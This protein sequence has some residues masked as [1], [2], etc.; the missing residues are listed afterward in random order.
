MQI[1]RFF[2]NKYVFYLVVFLSITNL[3]GY[4]SLRQY[5][6]LLFF[7]IV[8]LIVNFFTQNISIILLSA[9]LVTNIFFSPSKAIESMKGSS[10]EETSSDEEEEEPEDDNEDKKSKEFKDP[11]PSE[12]SSSSSKNKK[13]KNNNIDYQ[14]TLEAS[15]DNLQDILGNEGLTNLTKDTQRL[16]SKQ[17]EL[18]KSM[19][20][21]GPML[22]N[23]KSMLE[24][25][26]MKNLSGI[27]DIFNQMSST[28][29]K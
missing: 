27:G 1:D 15:Y 17:T 6:S 5:N 2:S 16:I 22:K 21:M 29:K 14:S 4:L 28:M 3:I 13:K 9:I 18:A 23:A 19:E 11:L 8:A 24:S 25:F 12:S 7:G 10:S 20:N 26:D